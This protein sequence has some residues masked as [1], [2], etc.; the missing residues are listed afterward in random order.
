MDDQLDELV[1]EVNSEHDADVER[2]VEAIDA[3]LERMR[4]WG[5]WHGKEK[6]E[7]GCSVRTGD[8]KPNFDILAGREKELGPV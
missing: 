4:R 5:G 7:Q 3:R 8:S 6:Q 1:N 2:W